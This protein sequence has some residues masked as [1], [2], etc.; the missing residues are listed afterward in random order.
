MPPL[1]HFEELPDDIR[2]LVLYQKHDVA[3]ERYGRDIAFM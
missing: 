1:P 3:H 2:D